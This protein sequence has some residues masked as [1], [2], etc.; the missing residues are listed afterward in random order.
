MSRTWSILI[1]IGLSIL[2]VVFGWEILQ[3]SGGAKSNVNEIIIPMP[4]N[5]LIPQE[6]SDQLINSSEYTNFVQSITEP[7]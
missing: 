5:T 7:N 4:R 1:I 3:I 6:L 2:F